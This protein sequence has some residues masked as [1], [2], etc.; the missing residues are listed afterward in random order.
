MN[1][2]HILLFNSKKNQ[3]SI[4]NRVITGIIT[5]PYKILLPNKLV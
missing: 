5:P 4:N 2:I 3:N 1:T